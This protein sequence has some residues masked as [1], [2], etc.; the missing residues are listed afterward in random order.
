MIAESIAVSGI[1]EGVTAKPA[2]KPRHKAS[3]EAIRS[4]IRAVAAW[5]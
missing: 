5:N 3:I 4:S 1:P 2:L